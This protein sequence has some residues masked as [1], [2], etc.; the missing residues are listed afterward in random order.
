MDSVR[1]FEDYLTN[2][3]A[4]VD[5]VA[6]VVNLALAGALAFILSLLYRRCGRSLSNRVTFSGNFVLITMTTMLII[7]IVKSS[8]ALS[9]GLVGALSIVRFRTALKEPEELAFVF[10]AI[11]IGL[12][13]GADQRVITVVAFFIIGAVILIRGAGNSSKS[14][15]SLYLTV[16]SNDPAR[17]GLKQITETL[18][19]HCG[20]VN[21]Q[22]FDESRD[23]VEASFQVTFRDFAQLEQGTAALRTLDADLVIAFLDNHGIGS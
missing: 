17:V 8:L 19:Q 23:A 18:M 1:S 16:S 7:T 9:L 4:Q 6:F 2:H 22:R 20:G 10:L 13:L 14:A 11:A 12:G 5:V 15:Q 21:L 3:S